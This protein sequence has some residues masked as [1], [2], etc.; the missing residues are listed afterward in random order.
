MLWLFFLLF[1]IPLKLQAANTGDIVINEIAWMGTAESYNN[2]WIE[3]YN[4]TQSEAILDGWILR[5]TDGTPTI[6]LAGTIAANGYFLLER[7]D[8]NTLPSQIADQIYTGALGNSGEHLE[9]ADNSGSVIDNINSWGNWFAGDNT[10]KQ[11]ME[12]VSPTLDGSDSTNWKTSASPGGTPRMQNSV[13]ADIQNQREPLGQNSTSTETDTE[14]QPNSTTT[15]SPFGRSPE[16]RQPPPSQ[17]GGESGVGE[18]ATTSSGYS[19]RVFINEL[20]SYPIGADAEMEWIEITNEGAVLADISFWRIQDTTGATNIYEFPANFIISPGAYLVLSRPTTK[21]TLNND[22]DGLRLIRPDDEIV[23]EINYTKAPNGKSFA[24]KDNQWEW[25]EVPT[26]GSANII[27]I[28]PNPIPTHTQPVKK[29][30][31]KNTSINTGI[32]PK[33]TPAENTEGLD[34]QAAAATNMTTDAQSQIQSTSSVPNTASL[35]YTTDPPRIY[36]RNLLT[37]LTASFIALFSAGF[38]FLLKRRLAK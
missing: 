37:A 2:E 11:T 7:T 6:H 4:T 12:R 34:V 35:A 5:A 22:A 36:N 30:A 28:S 32:L 26:P 10:T 27:S 19:S 14:F 3:L 31:Q 24:R 13:Y 18:N 16:G 15:P 8:D 17:G 38:I 20:M 23:R 25:T 33:P 9:L 21:I 1:F 29:N